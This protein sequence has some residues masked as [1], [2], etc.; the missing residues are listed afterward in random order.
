MVF[1]VP[2]WAMFGGFN[3]P[4]F[5]EARFWSAGDSQLEAFGGFNNPPFIEARRTP[6]GGGRP[7]RVRGV[8]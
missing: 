7:R 4:P 3:N 1:M 6:A 5:I 2:P 8:Q